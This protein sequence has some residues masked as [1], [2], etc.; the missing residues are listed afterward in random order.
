LV[1][2]ELLRQATS[3]LCWFM[4]F[5]SVNTVWFWRWIEPVTCQLKFVVSGPMCDFIISTDHNLKKYPYVPLPRISLL[6]CLHVIA[7]WTMLSD[8]VW[9]LGKFICTNCHVRDFVLAC[10]LYV[11]VM[12]QRNTNSIT[13]HFVQFD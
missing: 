10:I 11:I 2:P 8:R 12:I 3:A 13:G 4:S 7:F 6:F 5:R 1:I 9:Q